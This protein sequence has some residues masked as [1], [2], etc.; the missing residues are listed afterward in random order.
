M[1]ALKALHKSELLE[2]QCR[3]AA[4]LDLSLNSGEMGMLH[5]HAARPI[6]HELIKNKKDN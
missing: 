2:K 6:C 1:F 5:P 4:S 3:A